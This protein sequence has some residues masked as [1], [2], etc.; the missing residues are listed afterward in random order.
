MIHKQ[1]KS[2]QKI[3]KKYI[4]LQKKSQE[5]IDDLR[6]IKNKLMEYQKIIYLLENT[7]NQLSKL[8]TKKLIEVN[9]D[10]NGTHETNSQINFKTKVL[11]SSLCDYTDAYILVKG[12][13]TIIRGPESATCVSKRLGNQNKGVILTN[14]APFT[15]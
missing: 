6:L 3:S 14:C 5:I 8:R 10:S 15:T 1:R 12:T 2:Q 9:D 7:P 4:Y 13:I 11:N